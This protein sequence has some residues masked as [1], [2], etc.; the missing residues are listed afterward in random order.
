MKIERFEAIDR[1]LY[2]KEKETLI[3]GDL[4]LGY[5]ENLNES[6]ISIPKSQLEETI[7]IFKRIFLEIKKNGWKIKEIILLG[8][9]LNS[10]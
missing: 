4:H 1:C 7:N 5:E 6:G 9:K 3:V 2:W 10:N 8:N